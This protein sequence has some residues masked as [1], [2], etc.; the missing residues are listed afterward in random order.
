MRRGHLSTTANTRLPREEASWCLPHRWDELSL[1]GALPQPWVVLSGN[2]C[3]FCA[4]PGLAGLDLDGVGDFLWLPSPSVRG[5]W[6]PR[7]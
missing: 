1:E 5:G 3:C 2:T 4:T 7:A 6:Q